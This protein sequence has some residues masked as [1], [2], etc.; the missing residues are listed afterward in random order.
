MCTAVISFDP[1]AS[2][3]VLL[4]GVRDEFHDRKSLPPGHHWPDRPEL[5]GGQD[6]LAGGTW[7]AVDPGVPR[8]GCV[9]NGFGRPAPEDGRLSRGD[10]PLR[11]AAHGGLG[12]LDPARYDPFHLIC[13]T[14]D[15]V[16]LLSW[17]GEAFADRELE[18][19]LHM[20]TNLGLAGS[21]EPSA[22]P[23]PDRDAIRARIAHFLPRL[24][25]ARRPSP[26][27]GPTAAAW[28]DW[29]PLIDGDGLDPR[30]PRALVVRQE[31]G[32]RIAGTVST[33]LVALGRDTVRYDFTGTPGVPGGWRTVMSGSRRE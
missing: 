12:E 6:L 29:L 18:P 11:F 17:D 19:G 8:A 24:A 26:Q 32:G 23:G 5:V 33:T 16:R 30:D 13:A 14:L 31:V 15:E 21:T 3:P 27:S 9:L 4:A 25:A 7:L 1:A 10:L 20:V 22:G 28:G 2:I